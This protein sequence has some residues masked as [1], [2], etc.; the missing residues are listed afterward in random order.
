MKYS[1]HI[2]SASAFEDS[3][4]L[5]TVV[6]VRTGSLKLI[7]LA[8]KEARNE[9]ATRPDTADYRVRVTEQDSEGNGDTVL[10]DL[11]SDGETVSEVLAARLKRLK[12]SNNSDAPAIS[13]GE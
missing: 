1:L 13:A 11:S 2:A 3:S 5:H 10:L 4:A 8:A 9:L 6:D 7:E 12:K